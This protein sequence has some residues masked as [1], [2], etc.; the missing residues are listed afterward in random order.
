MKQINLY[1]DEECP[2]CK[3]YS[4]YIELRK[5]YEIKIVNARESINK[6][7]NFRENGFDINDGMIVELDDKIYQGADAAKLLDDCI[8]K[9]NFIDKFISFFVKVPIFKQIIYPIVLI[10]RRII[11]KIS[12]KN[13]DIKY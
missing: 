6:I 8:L 4:K 12:R 9:D 1:Y 13:P 2:F 10:F 11:L 3:K 5:K 7:N